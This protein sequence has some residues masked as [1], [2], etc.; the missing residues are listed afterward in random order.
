[1]TRW[2]AEENSDLK[3]Q[4]RNSKRL[5]SPAHGGGFTRARLLAYAAPQKVAPCNLLAE[6][7]F[8]AVREGFNT[9]LGQ[10]V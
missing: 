9:K 5:V 8:I 7:R 10:S 3:V 1:V 6:P 4:L 2:R